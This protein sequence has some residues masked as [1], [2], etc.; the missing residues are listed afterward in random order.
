MM[1]I[2][3]TDMVYPGGIA[4]ELKQLTGCRGGLQRIQVWVSLGRS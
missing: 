3:G 2:M 4:R 1:G